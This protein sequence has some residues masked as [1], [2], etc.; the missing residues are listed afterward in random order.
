[1][2]LQWQVPKLAG[3]MLMLGLSITACGQAPLFSVKVHRA[4]DRGAL[5]ADDKHESTSGIR[6]EGELS[7]ETFAGDRCRTL[8]MFIAHV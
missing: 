5:V 1:M 3:V 8:R 6:N 2:K 4:S 7:V